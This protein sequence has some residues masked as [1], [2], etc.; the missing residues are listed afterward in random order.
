MFTENQSRQLYVATATGSD[1]IAPV[2]VDNTHSATD[3][4]AK[5]NGACQIVIGP[6]KDEFYLEYKGPKDGVQRSDIV[7]KCNILSI[8]GTATKDLM[9]AKKKVEVALAS[10]LVS[11]SNLA[12]TDDYVLNVEIHN[13]LSSGYD[14]TKIKFG[15]AHG[16]QGE[17]ASDLY[18]KLA[19]SLAKNFAREGAALVAISLK[20]A[21]NPVSVTAKSTM[22][23][24]T[25][26]TA[27]GIILEEVEQ[28]WRLGA[29]KQEF[30]NFDVNPSTVYSGGVDVVWG[31]V[32]DA[33]PAKANWVAG[34]NAI[35]NS[36]TVADMEYFF[37]KNRGDVY[38][39]AG[40]PNNID[41][42][43]MVNPDLQY[44]YSF[45]DIHYYS[46]GNSH[47][48]GHS[49]KTLTIVVPGKA[50]D[51]EQYAQKLIG[52]AATTGQSATAATGLYA[53]VEGTNV[54]I[55][56]SESWDAS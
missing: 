8:T 15:A 28:P 2:E 21:S 4:S 11:S 46:E 48:I 1:I 43:Y 45:I 14:S 52:D 32:T 9:H 5:S 36:K 22:T 34:T 50:S 54:S 16:T 47:N 17:A 33:T 42:T 38:G 35:V 39:L 49:E 29:A 44:G 51:P 37:H 19:I 23:S 55:K 31:T 13:Y 7:K 3:L 6:N 10:G 40:S 56:L 41:T 25:S 53:I 20:T 30:V 12:V 18:K 24:L 26:T 27:T